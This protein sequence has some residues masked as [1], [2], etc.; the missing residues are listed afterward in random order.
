MWG[1]LMDL[2]LPT[3]FAS[4]TSTGIL[5]TSN[6]VARCPTSTISWTC[7]VRVFV[8]SLIWSTVASIS[9]SMSRP[10]WTGQE[11]ME[12]LVSGEWKTSCCMVL[13]SRHLVSRDAV[14]NEDITD[15]RQESRLAAGQNNLGGT[16]RRPRRGLSGFVP[17]QITILSSSN[18][19]IEIDT[20]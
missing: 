18:F 8:P 4:R 17:S 5:A 13:P 20:L 10:H 1:S 2:H 14:F 19:E 16:R 11:H 6:S 3:D 9:I 7:M 15:R 12:L